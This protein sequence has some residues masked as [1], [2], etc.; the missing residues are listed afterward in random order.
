MYVY[1]PNA[2]RRHKNDVTRAFLFCL[3]SLIFERI[4]SSFAGCV[5][6]LLDVTRAI[7]SR[8]DFNAEFAAPATSSLIEFRYNVSAADVLRNLCLKILTSPC[9]IAGINLPV[10]L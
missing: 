7:W 9:G 1:I 2:E 6:S 10:K 3:K 8:G 5:R 4:E